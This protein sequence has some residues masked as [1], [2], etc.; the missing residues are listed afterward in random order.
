MITRCTAS[1]LLIYCYFF[2][3]T[4]YNNIIL[5]SDE[6]F[7]IFFVFVIILLLFFF[8][9]NIIIT[10]TFSEAD[11]Y[12]II[13]IMSLSLL[14]LSLP[15][16]MQFCSSSPFGQ[17]FWPSQA[18]DWVMQ[19]MSAHVKSVLGQ[20]A[21]MGSTSNTKRATIYR[22]IRILSIRVQL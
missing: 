12:N 8:S 19:L 21:N 3:Y 18:F 4:L 6:K 20:G 10:R 2:V 5:R 1:V 15:Y 16:P 22:S 14:L 13:C 17:S 9:F 7:I 11:Q